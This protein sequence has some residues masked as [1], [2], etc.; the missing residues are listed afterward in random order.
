MLVAHGATRIGLPEQHVVGIDRFI[1]DKIREKID[2]VS[3]VPA[4]TWTPAAAQK[5]GYRSSVLTGR[6][7]APAGLSRGGQRR[8]EGTRIPPS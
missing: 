7:V 2:S 5:V 4:G 8:M 1:A 6:G 3:C